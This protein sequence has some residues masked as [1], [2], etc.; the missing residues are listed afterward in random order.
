MINFLSVYN[1]RFSFLWFLTLCPSFLLIVLPEFYSKDQGHTTELGRYE[2][3]LVY[4]NLPQITASL[5][6]GQDYQQELI[7]GT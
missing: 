7:H 2:G 5:Q 6:I 4:T 1:K 3:N